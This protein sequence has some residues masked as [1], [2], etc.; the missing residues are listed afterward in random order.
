MARRV[1][2]KKPI[3]ALYVG[4]TPAGARSGMSHTGALAGDDR[5]YNGMLAQAG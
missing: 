4:G 5:I 3:V 2:R 1:A